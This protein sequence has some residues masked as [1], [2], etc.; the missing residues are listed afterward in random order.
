MAERDPAKALQVLDL[1][2]EFFADGAHWLQ[3]D[4]R[5]ENGNRCLVGALRHL[6]RT[7]RSAMTARARIYRRPCR[8]VGL[9]G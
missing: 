4:F 9:A 1:L 3:G 7:M 2:L 5:D 8:T 6:R